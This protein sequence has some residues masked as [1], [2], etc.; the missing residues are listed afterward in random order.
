[1]T[2]SPTTRLSEELLYRVDERLE[3]FSWSH[4]LSE[5]TTIALQELAS[6]LAEDA[7][8]RMENL[9]G[10]PIVWTPNGDAGDATGLCLICLEER[11]EPHSFSECA[12][13]VS[14]LIAAEFDRG[15]KARAG[16]CE[17]IG[18]CAEHGRCWTHSK[19]EED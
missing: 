7:E 2:R 3:N 19:W 16:S 9:A 17:P 13:R 14:E 15:W 4:A 10:P 1:M 5:G 12:R 11:D 8:A 6:D 18:A